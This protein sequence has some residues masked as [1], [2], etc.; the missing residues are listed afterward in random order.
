MS[1]YLQTIR[2]LNPG[3]RRF[4]VWKAILP[5]AVA[6]DDPAWI[7]RAR[8]YWEWQRELYGLELS[9]FSLVIAA[10]LGL[11]RTDCLLLGVLPGERVLVKED[12]DA[13][14]K[15]KQGSALQ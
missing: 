13:Y 8:N 14:R 9:D 10:D 6:Q 11:V 12:T 15:Y 1:K 3:E 7:E 2:P 5:P 4:K